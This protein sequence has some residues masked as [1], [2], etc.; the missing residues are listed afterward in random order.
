MKSSLRAKVTVRQEV[1]NSPL[2][3]G[4]LIVAKGSSRRSLAPSINYKRRKKKKSFTVR[5]V[6]ILSFVP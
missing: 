5:I 2:Q 4:F 1:N 3:G 6:F